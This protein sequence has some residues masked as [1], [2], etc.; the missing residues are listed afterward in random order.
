EVRVVLLYGVA[1]VVEDGPAVSNPAGVGIYFLDVLRNVIPPFSLTRFGLGFRHDD[2]PA[3]IGIYVAFLPPEIRR[4]MLLANKAVNEIRFVV[5]L[6]V[7]KV[8][9]HSRGWIRESVPFSSA[10]FAHAGRLDDETELVGFDSG[11]I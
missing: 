2:V 1:F 11:A 10:L 9:F 7:E 5:V 8:V 6:P 3:A 4:T